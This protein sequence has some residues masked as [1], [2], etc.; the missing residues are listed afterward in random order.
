MKSKG[1]W[2]QRLRPLLGRLRR[3]FPL[4]L[5]GFFLLAGAVALLFYYGFVQQDLILLMTSVVILV[6]A[7]LDTLLVCEAAWAAY[8]W[9]RAEM[10]QLPQ[11]LSPAVVGLPAR[12]ALK[13]PPPWRPLLEIQWRWL[14]P[15]GVRVELVREP[16]GY[17]EEFVFPHRCQIV[18]VMREF[19][20]ADVLGFA[21]IR[22]RWHQKLQ[23]TVLPVQQKLQRSALVTSL[24]GGDELSDPRGDLVGDRVDMRQY[25]AGDPPKLLLWKL[26]ARTGKLMVRQPERAISPTPR[27][28]AYLVSGPQDEAS[29]G[30]MRSVLENG[31]IGSGWRFGADGNQ[32][33]CNTVEEA[34][35][36]LAR[37]GNPGSTLGLRAFLAQAAKDGFNG[38]LVAVP[39]CPGP[40]IEA[41]AEAARVRGIEVSFAAAPGHL[42]QSSRSQG[43]AWWIKAQPYLFF[44]PSEQ[45][46]GEPEV[47]LDRLASVAKERWIYKPALEGFIRYGGRARAK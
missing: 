39:S 5:S 17:Y 13:R 37:S 34:R 29:A 24:H 40:W 10:T 21:C 45:A 22:F 1:L 31:A 4:K 33:H 7:L 2:S 16:E 44:T 18:E 14:E 27:T 25:A 3:V 28:C 11:E 9:W 43:P 47:V 36:F 23:L 20:I 35:I 19:E 12:L 42:S 41:V 30:L 8:R 32:G 46:L 26:Y 38:C 6:V 15:Q